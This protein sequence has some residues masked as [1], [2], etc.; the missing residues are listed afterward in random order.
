MKHKA[1]YAKLL[2]IFFLAVILGLCA[3]GMPLKTNNVNTAL[4]SSDQVKNFN[5]DLNNA[6][7]YWA[8][9]HKG[10]AYFRNGDYEKSIEEYKKAIEII[11][12]I[13]GENW[14]DVSKEEMDRINHESH[15][16]KQIFSRYG[17]IEALE[18]IGQYEEALQ[19]VDWLKRNQIMK[20]KEE[21]LKKK[22]EGM[23]QNILQKMH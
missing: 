19:N 4:A 20:G 17:L 18:K 14:D 8:H 3:V 10:S 15:V 13:P 21:F 7:N 9:N 2:A 5:E 22:L 1:L 12:N 6:S 16:S 23:K 11:E